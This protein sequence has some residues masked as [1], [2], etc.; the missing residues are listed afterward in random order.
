[1]EN[2][3]GVYL[4]FRKRRLVYVGRSKNPPKRV[5]AHRRNG[6]AFDYSLTVNC[7]AEDVAWIERALIAALN[8][9]QNSLGVTAK[10]EEALEA[11]VVKIIYRD[12]PV[13]VDPPPPV[14]SLTDAERVA[15]KSGLRVPFLKDVRSGALPSAPKNPAFTGPRCRRVITHEDLT[16]WLSR[17]D[18]ARRASG[19][20]VPA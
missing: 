5:D 10:T 14:Y 16:R 1:M 8:P 11:Q 4:L 19:W 18:E 2:E 9:P 17:M 7:P 20:S 3:I 13:R 15:D 6:R 12:R